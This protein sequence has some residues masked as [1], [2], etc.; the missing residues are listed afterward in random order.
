M[1]ARPV[2][3]REP[4]GK[5]PTGKWGRGETQLTT[6]RVQLSSSEIFM[7]YFCHPLG[8]HVLTKPAAMTQSSAI[9]L[10]P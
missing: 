10:E 5:I 3:F 7:S 1:I 4:L 2:V 9:F 6:R 8:A